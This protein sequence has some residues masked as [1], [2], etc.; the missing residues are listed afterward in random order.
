MIIYNYF[1]K[2]NISENEKRIKC[3]TAYGFLGIILNFF[4]FIG[5]ITV[6]L[7]SGAI[8]IVADAFN[9]LS[10]MGSSLITLFGFKLASKKP[11][12]DHPFGHGRVEYISGL[13]V[14]II[15][16]LVGFE[17]LKTSVEKILNPTVVKFSYITVAIL[18]ASILVKLFMSYYNRKGAKLLNSLAM[19]ATSLDSFIDSIATTIVLVSML[20]SHFFNLQID[21]YAGIVISLFIFISGIRSVKE[22]I[23]PLL[24]QP[25]TKEFVEAV[26]RILKDCPYVCGIHD[27]IVHDYG[28]GRRILSV[29]AEVPA[30]VD[31]L[32]AHDVIDNVEKR[33]KEELNSEAVIHMDPIETDNKVIKEML[34][35]VIERVKNV[36]ERFTIHDFRVVQGDTH[37]NLIFDVVVPYELKLSDVEVKKRIEE[38]IQKINKTYFAVINIDHSFI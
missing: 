20:L 31:V 22:T 33:I 5:K 16:I 30:D 28:P 23:S 9:N 12:Q 4:L 13:I 34:E 6:G 37:T 24:G 2:K 18:G 10:D 1:N 29:H 26:E 27:L 17:L 7:I 8:S 36:D 38:E 14:S 35:R 32:K 3:A 25:P 19:K 21:A 11:D 15:I